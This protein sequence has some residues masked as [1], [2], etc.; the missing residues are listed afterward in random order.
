MALF[1]FIGIE[2][3]AITAK[4]VRDPRRNVGR[5]SLLGTAASAVL[6][7]PVTAAVM[8][9]VPHHA[10]VNNTA[11]FVDAFQA[12]FSH[13][14]WAGK[15]VAALAVVS[16][17][18]ALNGWTLV[19]CGGVAGRGRRTACSRGRSPGPTARDSAWFGIVLARAAAIGC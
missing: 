4:R 1:S 16:G 9:L 11:P 8:G 18:G 10:L 7:V 2:V 15:L 6:Y 3:A 13:G 17:I 14:A 5:A 19:D 12:I